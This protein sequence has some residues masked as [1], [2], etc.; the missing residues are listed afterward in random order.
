MRAVADDENKIQAE[1]GPKV[2]SGLQKTASQKI[3][4]ITAL[5]K[6]ENHA[7]DLYKSLISYKE[8]G[9]RPAV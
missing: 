8:D 9:F 4:D 3:V 2:I 1:I 6:A 5:R 7:Q